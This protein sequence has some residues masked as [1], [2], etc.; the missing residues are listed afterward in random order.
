MLLNCTALKSTALERR[1]LSGANKAHNG[2]HVLLGLHN[3]YHSVHS[4]V[5]VYNVQFVMYNL[6]WIVSKV[7]C[8]LCSVVYSVY[9][10]LYKLWFQ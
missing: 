10:L 2:R 1:R 6:Q 9:R 3:A 5:A 8:T 7:W 4:A